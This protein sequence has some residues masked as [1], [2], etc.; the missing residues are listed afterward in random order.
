M[1]EQRRPVIVECIYTYAEVIFWFDPNI[2][3][4][5]G[6]GQYQSG[7]ESWLLWHII[8]RA[9]Y[10]DS[11]SPLFAFDTILQVQ[12]QYILKNTPSKNTIAA[13]VKIL[14]LLWQLFS[15]FDSSYY[16]KYTFKKYNLVKKYT[17]RNTLS[18]YCDSYSLLF[19][20]STILQVHSTNSFW[21]IH[22]HKIQ[23]QAI[24]TAILH[25]LLELQYYK[26]TFK[27]YISKNTPLKNTSAALVK[28]LLLL[29]Q[30][31]STFD[32]CYNTTSTLSKSTI[33]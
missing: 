7:I 21:K 9:G 20:R 15:T 5:W 28:I 2:S 10:C 3:G 29:W 24:V 13:L 23:L 6:E 17:F 14:L 32:S 19:A 16:Y 33:W 27:K 11:Y 8:S 22:L 25:C 31:F 4:V 1:C 18:C 26:Y 12:V 30:L